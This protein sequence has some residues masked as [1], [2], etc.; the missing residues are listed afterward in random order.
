[1]RPARCG[2]PHPVDHVAQSPTVPLPT[3]PADEETRLTLLDRLGGVWGL[4]GTG[5]PQVVFALLSNVTT[6]P[7]TAGVALAVAVVLG[8][9]RKLRGEPLSTALGGVLGVAVAVGIALWTGSA[10]NYFLVGIVASTLALVGTVVSLVV[11]RPL[12]GLA[13]NAI[14]G[15][16]HAWRDDRPSRRAH[17]VATIATAGMFA[18]RSAVSGWLWW[19]DSTEGLAV[20]RVV[21]GVPLTALVAIVVFWAFR[22]TT[23]RL[24]T[25]ARVAARRGSR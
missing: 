1:M 20:A 24:V 3:P 11:R 22:R 10:S 25:P 4:I 19:V 12:T 8:V 2:Y 18:A 9:V 7:V 21:L 23:N 13:W 6:L 17:L 14:H 16:G 5:V 15:G